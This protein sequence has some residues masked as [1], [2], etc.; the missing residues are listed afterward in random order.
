MAA[1]RKAGGKPRR[2]RAN[3]LIHE[4][5]MCIVMMGDKYHYSLSNLP[6]AEWYKGRTVCHRDGT[7]FRIGNMELVSREKLCKQCVAEL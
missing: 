2:Q 4:P 1:R 6:L 5:G 7:L 3:T